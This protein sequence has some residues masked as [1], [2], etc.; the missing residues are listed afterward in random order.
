VP[1][2][3]YNYK[4]SDEQRQTLFKGEPIIIENFRYWD[5]KKNDYSGKVGDLRLAW[6]ERRGEHKIWSR[7][8][9]AEEV[10][11]ARQAKEAKQQ[12]TQ[13]GDPMTMPQS[14]TSRAQSQTGDAS[15][16]PNRVEIQQQ[17]SGE[18]TEPKRR[19][20]KPGS[21]NKPKEPGEGSKKNYN[22]AEVTADF[23][24]EVDIAKGKEN[25]Q[26]KSLS[27]SHI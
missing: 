4:L 1:A 7:P 8:A 21:K 19:G 23:G 20:R 22:R 26:E 3:H 2:E 6:E 10:Q 16:Q 15:L 18:Q 5:Q 12:Q 17:P 27:Q 13:R 25:I 14:P 11:Q 24:Q 9:T